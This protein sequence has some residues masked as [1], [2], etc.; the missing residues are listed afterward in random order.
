MTPFKIRQEIPPGRHFID[1]PPRTPI[2]S[3][4]STTRNSKTIFGV[5][6]FTSLGNSINVKHMT[7]YNRWNLLLMATPNLNGI[8]VTWDIKQSTT[9]T[10]GAKPFRPKSQGYKEKIH[11]SDSFLQWPFWFNNFAP[12]P[13]PRSENGK[14]GQS[15]ESDSPFTTQGLSISGFA[16]E[17]RLEK[18][19]NTRIA[20]ALDANRWPVH[21]KRD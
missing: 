12:K 17:E 1:T 11:A 18:M 21:E 10:R 6:T 19:N 14:G 5:F 13:E 15:G 3:L 20:F 4:E 9:R 2:L 16:L 8:E 7:I